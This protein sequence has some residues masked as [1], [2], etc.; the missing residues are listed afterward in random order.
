MRGIVGGAPAV[1]DP[2]VEKLIACLDEHRNYGN[3]SYEAICEGARAGWIKLSTVDGRLDRQPFIYNNIEKRIMKGSAPAHVEKT[4]FGRQ[5]EG[6]RNRF[7]ERAW[8]DF[9]V[10]YAA[11]VKSAA[12]DRDPRSIKIFLE[13]F[14]GQPVKAIEGG[15]SA[16]VVKVMA[17]LAQ[18]A[19]SPERIEYIDAETGEARP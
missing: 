1:V 15:A 4:W 2:E 17:A 6:N 16:D 18:Q 19:R 12:E 9:D 7:Q 11:L 5:A 13:H 3:L 10:V 14:L 8:D